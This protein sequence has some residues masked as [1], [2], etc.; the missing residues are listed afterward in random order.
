[1]IIMLRAND[2]DRTSNGYLKMVPENWEHPRNSDGDLIYLSHEDMPNWDKSEC[3]HYQVYESWNFGWPLTPAK[4]S[5]EDLA[6]WLS[7]NKTPSGIGKTSKEEWLQH[8]NSDRPSI[9]VSDAFFKTDCEYHRS[10]FS[11]DDKSES[12]IEMDK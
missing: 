6:S 5:K 1:M 8:L 11:Y 9:P 4:S 12:D 3:T 10:R 7:D 2:S